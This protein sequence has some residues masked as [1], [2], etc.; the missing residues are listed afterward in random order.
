MEQYQILVKRYFKNI[1]KALKNFQVEFLFVRFIGSQGGE[2][3]ISENINGKKLTVYR[4][5]KVLVLKLDREKIF[6]Y[7]IK[8]LKPISIGNRWFLAYQRFD[9][10]DRMLH[11]HAGY[12]NQFE[13]Y[14][15][16][17]DPKLPEIRNTILRSCNEHYLI[18]ITFSGKIPI[19]NVGLVPGYNNWYNWEIV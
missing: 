11:S 3:I 15:G 16:P 9:S 12:P 7:E 2:V 1:Q 14:T 10:K 8:K 5:K 18:E 6:V 13:P 17:D 19:K 4:N